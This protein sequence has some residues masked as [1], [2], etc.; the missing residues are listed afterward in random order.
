M[1]FQRNESNL[2][3]PASYS[4]QSVYDIRMVRPPEVATDENI[5][6]LAAHSGDSLFM[7][8]SLI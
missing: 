8:H 1:T 6:Q 7:G 2:D 4:I 5:Q 3:N